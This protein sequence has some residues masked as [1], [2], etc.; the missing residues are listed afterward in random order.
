MVSN[1][2]WEKEQ[3]ESLTEGEAQ[4]TPGEAEAAQASHVELQRRHSS[5]SALGLNLENVC[6]GINNILQKHRTTAKTKDYQSPRSPNRRSHSPTE[7]QRRQ[8]VASSQLTPSFLFLH[9]LRVRDGFH[10]GTL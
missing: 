5:N 10:Q 4:A 6:R 2:T 3:R 7:L 1:A 8:A 9:Q